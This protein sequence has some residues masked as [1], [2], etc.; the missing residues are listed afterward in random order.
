ML[1]PAGDL[2][3]QVMDFIGGGLTSIRATK[4]PGP[5]GATLCAGL[6]WQQVWS[7]PRRYQVVLVQGARPAAARQ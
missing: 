2:T 6:T 7:E 3:P 1:N 4:H 5:A